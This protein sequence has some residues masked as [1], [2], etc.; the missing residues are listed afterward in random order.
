MREINIS[1][2]KEGTREKKNS[3]LLKKELEKIFLEFHENI[4]S[5]RKRFVIADKLIRLGDHKEIDDIYRAQIVFLESALDYYIHRLSEFAMIQISEGNW[6]KTNSY[7]NFS[8]PI[9]TVIDA[10]SNPEDL[11]WIRQTIILYHSSKTFMS[12]EAIKKQL[13]L[14]SNDKLFRSI[15]DKMY[16]VEGSSEKTDK[17]LMKLLNDVFKRRNRIAHQS[18]RD[19]FTGEQYGID[20]Q[21]TEFF[22]NEIFRF[23]ESLYNE[24]IKIYE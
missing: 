10:L 15:A 22:I 7:K 14:M 8:V 11:A 5:I 21:T 13:S 4:D 19:H 12:S 2:R 18:D 17:K 23:A 24:L 20:R 6:D 3:N 16:C 9:E 1:S